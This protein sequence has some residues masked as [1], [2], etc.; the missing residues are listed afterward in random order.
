MAQSVQTF[1]PPASWPTSATLAY[2][3]GLKLGLTPAQATDFA[4]VQYGESGFNPNA[5]NASSG[6][7]GLYQLLS[8]GYVTR[9]NQLG[10][11]L[12]PQANIEAILPS[13][14][15]Y[16]L[17][18]PG[19]VIPGA[20][21]SAV[22][23]SGQPA[24][25]YAQGYQHL[26]GAGSVPVSVTAM[27][28]PKPQT[29]VSANPLDQLAETL[30][31][32][33]AATSQAG[34]ANPLTALSEQLLGSPIAAPTKI[35][36]PTIVA[37][38]H[39]DGTTQPTPT[40]PVSAGDASGV[41]SSGH[42]GGVHFSGVP[43]AGVRT[44]LLLNIARAV[45]AVGGTQVIVTSGKRPPGPGNDVKDSNHITGNAI[46]GYAIING[47]RIPLGQAIL[48][49]AGKFGLRSGDVAGF[50]PKTQGGWDPIHVDDGANVGGL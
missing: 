10:G 49:V 44:P 37:P 33:G 8:P 36:Q 17:Q 38:P 4:T 28:Q 1:A 27:A 13:Y 23:R 7:A 35:K 5:R 43:T 15:Q 2:N 50:D 40:V 11:V 26:T 21:G 47:Q 24:S 41:P 31:G 22:E 39:A 42:L 20:A 48:H 34:A 32:V 18:H 29:V 46:D 16:Y 14:K 6:A 30:I 45:R 12:N 3:D 19:Q 25:Y 9:A